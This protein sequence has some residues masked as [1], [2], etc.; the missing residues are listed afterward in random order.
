MSID[1]F[2]YSKTSV[3]QSLVQFRFHFTIPQ[4]VSFLYGSQVEAHQ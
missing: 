2:G 4:P 3:F 1:D